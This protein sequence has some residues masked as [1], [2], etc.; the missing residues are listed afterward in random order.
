MK[1]SDIGLVGLAVMG[2][3]LAINLESKGYRVSLYNRLHP[4]TPQ[5]V[6]RFLASQGEAKRFYPTYSLAELVESLERPRKILLMIRAGEPVDETL[7]ALL[8]LLSRGDIVIDGGNSDY[9]DTR[10]RQQTL[11]EKGIYL[12]GCGISGGEEGALHGPSIMPG[13]DEAVAGEVLPLLQAIAARLDDGTPCCA[14]TGPD[15]SGHFVKTVHNGIEYG[16]MQLIAETYS[17]LRIK[18]KNDHEAMAD[19]FEAWNRGVLESYL[20][21]I[22]AP[23]LRYREDARF[24][25]DRAQERTRAH[26]LYPDIDPSPLLDLD[27]DDLHHALYAAK[28]MAYAQG[29]DLLYQTSVQYDWHL[30]LSTLATIWRKGCII[31]S[32][33]L[34]EIATV[35]RQAGHYEPLLFNPYFREKI[36]L[37][38]P[39]WRRVV[40]AALSAGV[41]LPALTAALTAFDGWRCAKSPANLIQ[42]QRDYFGAHLYERV[43]APEGVLFHTDWL[44]RE[45]T[46]TPQSTQPD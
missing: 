46:H 38:L 13:G 8:P 18:L 10:R 22:T 37:C 6:D 11:R 3:N 19:T 4:H 16:D 32:R 21:G 20:I 40:G 5:V 29:F 36:S 28:I 39:S 9:R 12:V 33:F 44:R 43:D 1:K 41:A 45:P 17:L 26:R 15:G 30:N 14:W 23:I 35:Y 27:V 25:S 34:R 2:E 7:A 42:A 31:Q 24:L